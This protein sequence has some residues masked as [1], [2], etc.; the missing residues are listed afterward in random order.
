[1]AAPVMTFNTAGNVLASQSLAASA[2]V[3]VDLNLSGQFEGQL[4]VTCTFG[5]VAAT[6]GLKID[7]LEGYVATPTNPTVNPN[8][9]YTI[10]SVSSTN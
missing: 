7:I 10:P 2:T 5:T 8:F 4:M 6:S 1:M 9:T 3:T